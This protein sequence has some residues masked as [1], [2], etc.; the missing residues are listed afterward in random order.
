MLYYLSFPHQHLP[1]KTVLLHKT[2]TNTFNQCNIWNYR[3]GH[4]SHVTVTKI[5][6]VFPLHNFAKNITLCDPCISSKYKRLPLHTSNIHAPNCI[7]LVHMDI[8]VYHVQAW[9][10]VIFNCSK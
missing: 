4:P 8:W 10:Q 5:N 7:D 1:H 2:M 6:K 9:P 3:L